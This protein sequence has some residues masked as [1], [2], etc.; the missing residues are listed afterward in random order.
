[1]MSATYMI[2]GFAAL[3]TLGFTFLA[4][5]MFSRSKT[6][7]LDLDNVNQLMS[8]SVI[9]NHGGYYYESESDSYSEDET[10]YTDD[11]DG[12][13]TRENATGQGEY[14]SAVNHTQIKRPVYLHFR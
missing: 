2:V 10:E 8:Y 7:K 3:A 13:Y 11:S 1:M 4:V 14:L 9:D 5:T 12:Y 6:S